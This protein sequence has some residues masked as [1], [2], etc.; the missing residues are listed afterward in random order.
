MLEQTPRREADASWMGAAYEA[1]YENSRS[2]MFLALVLLLVALAA[3]VVKDR[4][5]WFGDA[6]TA[7]ADETPEWVPS[8]VVQPP[9]VPA[10]SAAPAKKHVAVA[11][12]STE[13]AVA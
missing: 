1:A 12:S 9:T 7:V 11:K 8:H 6:E 13:P 4:D 5:F 3:V 10:A 2:R